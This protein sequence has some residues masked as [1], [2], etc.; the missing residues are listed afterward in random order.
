[1]LQRLQRAV[2]GLDASAAGAGRAFEL[3]RKSENPWRDAK[4]PLAKCMLLVCADELDRMVPNASARIA[5]K[6]H[7][8]YDR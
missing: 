6:M 2:E 8:S 5:G 4:E 1:M 3:V 7:E